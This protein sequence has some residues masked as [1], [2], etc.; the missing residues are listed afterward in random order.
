MNTSGAGGDDACTTPV[1]MPPVAGCGIYGTVALEYQVGDA[2][3]QLSF[4]VRLRTGL[5]GA[6]PLNQIEVHYYLSLEE[7]S[8]FQAVVDSFVLH[9]PDADYTATSQI[10]IVQLTPAQ[11][12]SSGGCQTHFIRIRNTSTAILTPASQSGDPYVEFHVKLT[13]NN[14]AP[15]NQTHSNDQSYQPASTTFQSNSAMGVFVC[16]QL[17]SGCTPGDSG[18][19]G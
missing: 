18:P 4:S 8:G 15:P 3:S 17:V 7:D 10:G 5:L 12:S 6:V 9:T 19:C 2:T 16:G 1:A 13:P 11:K 14:A